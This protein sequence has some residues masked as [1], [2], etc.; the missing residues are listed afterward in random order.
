MKLWDTHGGKL[1]R[2]LKGHYDTVTS[3]A[4]D[5]Q[6]DML[7][8]GSLD[9]TA[10]PPLVHGRVYADFLDDRHY[11]TTV[12]QLILSLYDLL[13]P[14]DPAVAYLREALSPPGFGLRI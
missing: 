4:F 9:R 7:A 14:Y 10:L 12:F 11:F 1:L 5:S 6:A 13:P 2:T 3:L 8:S